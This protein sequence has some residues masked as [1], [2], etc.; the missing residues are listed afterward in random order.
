MT[1]GKYLMIPIAAGYV[2]FS[3]G[4]SKQDLSPVNPPNLEQTTPRVVDKAK[5]FVDDIP[6][7]RYHGKQDY[8]C[9][10]TW[11]HGLYDGFIDVDLGTLVTDSSDVVQIKNEKD[12]D[13]KYQTTIIVDQNGDGKPEL[14]RT[15]GKDRKKDSGIKPVTS[16][17]VKAFNEVK[18]A[19][20][21]RL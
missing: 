1:L 8:T 21:R 9:R 7:T 11:I 12:A 18:K 16:K 5:D 15:W 3:A 13:G 14:Y 2:L 19:A 4:C 10:G 17:Q 20:G 6:L